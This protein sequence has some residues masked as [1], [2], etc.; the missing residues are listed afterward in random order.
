[1]YLFCQSSKELVLSGRLKMTHQV[2]AELFNYEKINVYKGRLH[3]PTAYIH[4]YNAGQAEQ[5]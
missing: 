5:M 3:N 4:N 2:L 1:M